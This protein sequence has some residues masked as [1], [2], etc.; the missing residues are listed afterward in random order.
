MLRQ[1]GRNITLEQNLNRVEATSWSA[2][3]KKHQF[4][5]A[6]EFHD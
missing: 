2:Q 4:Q 3:D 6:R 5:P 1:D